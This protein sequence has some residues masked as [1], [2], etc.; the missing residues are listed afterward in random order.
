MKAAYHYR[1]T[2]NLRK[3]GYNIMD[4]ISKNG[5]TQAKFAEKSGISRQYMSKI[6]NGHKAPSFQYL[7]FIATETGTDFNTLLGGVIRRT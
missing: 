2:L 7:A 3:L 1:I 6:I 5:L 4:A